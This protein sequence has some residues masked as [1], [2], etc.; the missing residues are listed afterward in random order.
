M[1][2]RVRAVYYQV[3]DELKEKILKGDLVPGEMI[4]SESQLAEIYSISRTTVRQGIGLLVEQGYLYPVQGKGYFVAE[5]VL[6]RITINISEQN[7]LGQ[8]LKVL[9]NKMDIL[10]AD[11]T[12]IS[13]LGVQPGETT[14]RMQMILNCQEGPVAVDY[15]HIPY[16]KGQPLLEKE[17]NY[18]DFPEI[19]ARHSNLVVARCDFTVA[20]GPI[21]Q[22]DAGILGVEAGFP[23][24]CVEQVLYDINENP[25]GWSKMIC[26]SDRYVMSGTTYAYSERA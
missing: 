14:L 11:E 9:M 8:K 19:V 26:R 10:A 24:L 1:K 12:L 25:L 17:L 4:P 18:A 22:D 16:R 15:R 7:L 13:K 6:N 21:N 23:A 5:P 3:A 2:G 20:A